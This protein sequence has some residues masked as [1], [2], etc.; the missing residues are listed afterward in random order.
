MTTRKY[1]VNELV[2]ALQGEGVRAGTVNIFLRFSGC[3]LQCKG[4]RIEESGAYQPVCDTEFVSGRRVTL[5]EIARWAHD[6]WDISTGIKL[7]SDDG[8]RACAQWKEP[9]IILT[10]GEPALQVD[11]ELVDFFHRRGCKLAMETNGTVDVK[12]L[13]L[14]WITLSPKVAEHAIKC[15][16]C[17]EVKYVRSYGQGIPRPRAESEYFLISPASEGGMIHTK[18]L[19]WCQKLVLSHPQWRLSCQQ[20]HWWDVR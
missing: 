20:H 13:D 6:E 2:L 19:Q 8:L 17:D 3:N 7:D 10:G 5:E 18:T 15:L 9:W 16:Q 1:D 4:D 14:D 11:R 12:R